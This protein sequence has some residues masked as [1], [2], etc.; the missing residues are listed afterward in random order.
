MTISFHLLH[1]LFINM[2]ILKRHN[3]V[4][5]RRLLAYLGADD[6]QGLRSFLEG[7]SNQDFR[8]A[9]FLLGEKLLPKLANSPTVFWNSFLVLVSSNS[10]AY[11]GTFLKAVITL[12][13]AG[14]FN[15]DVLTLQQFADVASP[16][17]CRKLLLTLLPVVRTVEEVRLLLHLYCSDD[18][19][20]QAFYLLSAGTLPCYYEMFQ[21]LKKVEHDTKLLR[22]YSVQLMQRGDNL[23]Y[24]MAS[25]LQS[26]FALGELPGTFSLRLRDYEL[27][28][29]DGSFELF[30]KEILKI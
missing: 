8:T 2:S 16:I 3:P 28:R 14:Q 18:I 27:S 19:P 15:L 22:T 13:S 26:Y 30:K 4:L 29:L 24:N 25:I 23:S 11:L 5:E 21:Q 1:S 12:Y 6:I 7:L 20:A 10:K 9:G 17:D